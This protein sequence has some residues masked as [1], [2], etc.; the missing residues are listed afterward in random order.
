VFGGKSVVNVVP[1]GA[2]TKADAVERLAARFPGSPVLYV[3]DD[4]TDEDAF[5]SRA[6]TWSVRVGREDASG[7]AY[8]LDD[9]L[10]VDALL[11]AVLFEH[12]RHGRPPP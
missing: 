5:R 9:Q 11:R 4:E 10:E 7:A 1:E 3:G 12:A 8:Y 6:V 2:E